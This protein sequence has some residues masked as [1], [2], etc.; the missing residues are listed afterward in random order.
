[1]YHHTSTVLWKKDLDLDSTETSFHTI[2]NE[3]LGANQCT[4]E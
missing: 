4:Q 1:M 2:G 3:V